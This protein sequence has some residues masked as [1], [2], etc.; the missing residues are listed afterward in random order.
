MAMLTFRDPF[1]SLCA[2]C[3]LCGSFSDPQ[4]ER[5][6]T[7]GAKNCGEGGYFQFLPYLFCP[8]IE[9]SFDGQSAANV[10][11]IYNWQLTTVQFVISHSPH[12]LL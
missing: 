12:E 4:E 2:L 1:L 5:A 8:F 10:S 9:K 7:C 11:A 6:K 3:V